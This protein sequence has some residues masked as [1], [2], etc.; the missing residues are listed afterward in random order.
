ML[1]AGSPLSISIQLCLPLHLNTL[2]AAGLHD[3]CVEDC[4]LDV[5]NL[6]R[7]FQQLL[8]HDEHQLAMCSLQDIDLLLALALVLVGVLPPCFLL[9][10]AL[11]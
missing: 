5:A 3:Q 11:G 8:D 10:V 2:S 7:D 1:G 9:A 4:L 6:L